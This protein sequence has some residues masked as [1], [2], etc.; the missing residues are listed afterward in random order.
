MAGGVERLRRVGIGLT[1][2]TGLAL[3]GALGV[4]S[5]VAREDASR[6]PTSLH[7]KDKKASSEQL[8][9]VQEVAKSIAETQELAPED[10]AVWED[11]PENTMVYQG[12][13]LPSIDLVI[14]DGTFTTHQF[15]GLYNGRVDAKISGPHGGSVGI[16][17]MTILAPPNEERPNGQWVTVH[18]MDNFNVKD[19]RVDPKILPDITTSPN[20]VRVPH[21]DLTVVTPERKTRKEFRTVLQETVGNPIVTLFTDAGIEGLNANQETQLLYNFGYNILVTKDLA[22]YHT[23]LSEGTTKGYM[24]ASDKRA[25]ALVKDTTKFVKNVVAT[26][27]NLEDLFADSQFGKIVLIDGVEGPPQLRK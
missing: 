18:F 11:A 12:Q 22:D 3:P 25:L 13:E 2:A 27:G 26:R 21:D 16:S 8:K 10:F 23:Y 20:Y 5:A 1:V 4:P 6:V 15:M 7:L 17:F 24:F 19:P 14:V 9:Q